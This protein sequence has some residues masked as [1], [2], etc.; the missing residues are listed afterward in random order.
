MTQLY[1]H[2]E[3]GR[4]DTDGPTFG[5]FEFVQMTYNMLRI[6]DGETL[7]YHDAETDEWSIG[8]L[9]EPFSDVII[10]DRPDAGATV[11]AW[12]RKWADTTECKEREAERIWI[13]L[14][15]EGD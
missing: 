9:H 5:P 13:S 2:F 4:H 11:Y 15:E 8:D 6:T 14:D 3:R 10:C 7:A 1:V 12:W